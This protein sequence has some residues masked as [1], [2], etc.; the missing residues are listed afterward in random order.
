MHKKQRNFQKILANLLFLIIFS[1]A[2]CAGSNTG[3]AS[4]V[5][6]W[7]AI[8]PASPLATQPASGNSPHTLSQGLYESCSPSKG[9]IC[10]NRL[11]QMAA[12]G[13]TVVIN[14]NQLDATAAQELAYAQKAH[15]LGMKIIWDM[16]DP[17]FRNAGNILRQYQTLAATCNCSDDAGFIRYYVNLVKNL[18]ATW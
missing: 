3:E 7:P 9:E 16:D 6:T 17:V 1:L 2:G 8:T 18:P 4:P 12:A 13:F 5:P 10:L 15:E 11:E 14:Y